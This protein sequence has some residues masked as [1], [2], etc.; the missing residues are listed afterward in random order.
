VQQRSVTNLVNRFRLR[1]TFFHRHS[2]QLHCNFTV[3]HILEPLP[4]TQR[5]TRDISAIKQQRKPK[6]LPSVC[7]NV[8]DTVSHRAQ[9]TLPTVAGKRII[10]F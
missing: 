10:G 8:N 3:C 5:N 7:E 9:P 2:L 1:A 4:R 6:L